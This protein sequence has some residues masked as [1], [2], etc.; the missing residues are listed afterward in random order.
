[1]DKK[2]QCKS[3]FNMFNSLIEIQQIYY[4]TLLCVAPKLNV[5]HLR[6]LIR[7][8]EESLKILNKYGCKKKK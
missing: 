8:N 1:M 4:Q 6:L 5:R 7:N 2:K 3:N